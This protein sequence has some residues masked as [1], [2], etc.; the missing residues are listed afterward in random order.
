LHHVTGI[1]RVLDCAHDPGGCICRPR[2]SL[3]PGPA[4]YGLSGLTCT[5][6]TFHQKAGGP[7]A[8]GRQPRSCP[9]AP[10]HQPPGPRFPGDPEGAWDFGHGPASISMPARPP[11]HATYRMARLRGAGVAGAAGWERPQRTRRGLSGHF[12]GGGTGPGVP[13]CA[14]PGRYKLC[15]RH[16]PHQP[17]SPALGEKPSVVPRPPIAPAGVLDCVQLIAFSAAAAGRC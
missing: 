7:S 2:P 17:P 9:D 5:D 3:E 4:L 14:N 1:N 10:G 13:P 12:D 6:G 16:S 8:W 11:G 15:L